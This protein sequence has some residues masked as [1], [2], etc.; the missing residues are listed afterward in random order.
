MTELATKS[1][2]WVCRAGIA[3]YDV[4]AQGH[5]MVLRAQ[6]YPPAGDGSFT[7]GQTE[8][9]RLE[10]ALAAIIGWNVR[11]SPA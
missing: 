1:S 11:F 10:K 5:C 3:L 9:E 2:A 8:P 6:Q 4:I 7:P